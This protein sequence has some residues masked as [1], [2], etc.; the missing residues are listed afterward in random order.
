MISRQ[1]IY[2]K[3]NLLVD[4]LFNSEITR[5][6]FNLFVLKV[7]VLSE[8][9]LEEC[10]LS[11]S[12]NETILSVVDRDKFLDFSIGYVSQMREWQ[13]THSPKIEV[14]IEDISQA[15]NRAGLSEKE[16]GI[17]KQCFVEAGVGTIISLGLGLIIS[18]TTGL[19]ASLI[20]EIIVLLL[21]KRRYDKEKKEIQ[22]KADE[23][24]KMRL[25][26]RRDYLLNLTLD[27][28]NK[29]LDEAEK[30]SDRIEKTFRI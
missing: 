10:F 14:Q 9:Y 1:E 20:A 2:Q 16:K 18:G 27:D 7:K 19:I 29:W 23:E 17:V 15:C 5:E 25:Q 21:V 30:E 6:S 12:E 11:R 13:R 3:I 8:D 26:M 24:I 4:N 22:I 28:V